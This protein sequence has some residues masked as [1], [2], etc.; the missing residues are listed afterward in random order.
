MIDAE[1]LE[2]ALRRAFLATGVVYEFQNEIT[3][4]LDRIIAHLEI[5]APIKTDPPGSGSEAEFMDSVR[6][7]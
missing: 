7:L 5:L 2:F 3:T 6:N 4:R 1:D